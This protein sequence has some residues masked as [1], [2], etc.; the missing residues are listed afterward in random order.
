MILKKN[1]LLR[2]LVYAGAGG[3]AGLGIGHLVANPGG[4]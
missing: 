1:P 3:L 4:T 2:H